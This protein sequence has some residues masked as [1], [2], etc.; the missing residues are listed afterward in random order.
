[1]LR[2]CLQNTTLIDA[3]LEVPEAKP[4]KRCCGRQNQLNFREI[5]RLADD[6]NVALHE[7]AI[8]PLLRPVCS[9]DISHLQRLERHRQFILMV[10]EISYKR[11][12]QVIAKASVHKICLA[13][14]IL[15]AKLLSA[16]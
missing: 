4:S 10:G 11:N 15:Q 7:L 5:R 12:G 16:L 3:D 13:P 14:C 2:H 1:M 6:V 9:P 8:A